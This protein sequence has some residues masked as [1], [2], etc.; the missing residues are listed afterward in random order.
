M[1]ACNV[2]LEGY[3]IIRESDAAWGFGEPGSGAIAFWLPKSQVEA[4]TY[5]DGSRLLTSQRLNK[6]LASATIPEWLA[7][8]KG[9]EVL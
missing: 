3:V 9:L 6:P 5:A 1:P 8:S 7:D 2:D 4:I